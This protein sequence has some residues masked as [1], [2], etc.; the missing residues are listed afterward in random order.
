MISA[1]DRA[2]QGRAN[3][4]STDLINEDFLNPFRR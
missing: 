4:F 2:K 1:A 3:M